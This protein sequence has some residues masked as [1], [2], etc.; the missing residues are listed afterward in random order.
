MSIFRRDVDLKEYLK[1]A[2]VT[3]LIILAN[4]FMLGLTLTTGGFD[5]YNL[6]RLGGLYAPLVK[7][8][9]YYR[10]LTSMFLHGGFVHFLANAIIGLYVLSSSLERMIG[11]KKFAAIYFISGLGAGLLITFTTDN[12]TIGASGAIFGALGSLLF[13]TIYRKDLMS[14]QDIQSIR[15]LVFVNIFFT[16]LGDNIS[17]AGHLG[18][19]ITGFI[20][21]F[22]F[23]RG[24]KAK[25]IEE[26]EVYD[27]TVS[28]D[29]IDDDE[30]DD[31]WD[32]FG[33]H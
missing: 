12:L 17:I 30:N 27:F 10:L 1:Q 24:V 16:F 18:G 29:E 26:F 20:I 15:G 14:P 25:E 22:I 19:I 2:P 6:L 32:R 31:V 33:S 3:S 4:A 28:Q 7:D 11:S 23:L 9:E 5:P 13:V 8:G 21:S